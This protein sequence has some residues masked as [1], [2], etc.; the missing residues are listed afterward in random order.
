M[1]ESSKQALL[2]YI[3]GFH[4]SPLSI[5][6][7]QTKQYLQRCRPEVAFIAPQLAV[8]PEP[9]IEQLKTLLLEN[10]HRQIALM[11][12]SL[13]GF[14]ALYL[15]QQFGL[16]TV[17]INPSV[18]P[19]VTIAQYLGEQ[20]QPYTQERYELN[21]GHMQTLTSMQVNLQPHEYQ[22][23]MLMLQTGDE[24]L[25]FRQASARLSSMRAIIEYGGDHSFINFERWLPE[26]LHFLDI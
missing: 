21:E 24:T 3:H 26:I 11:G 6:A 14:F 5:K 12:S 19:D 20:I 16:R 9:A 8:H 4:S 1:I 7:Q 18:N 25:D 10:K 2:I 17:L 15:G 23:F 22:N 13:G